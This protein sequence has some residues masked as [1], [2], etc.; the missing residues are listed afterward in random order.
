MNGLIKGYNSL[1]WI[2]KTVICFNYFTL[3]K[4]K[5]NVV[6]IACVVDSQIDPNS[7]QNKVYLT[8]AI[9]DKIFFRTKCTNFSF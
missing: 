6:H 4:E 5:K 7:K 8:P 1:V 9:G 3:L 2:N